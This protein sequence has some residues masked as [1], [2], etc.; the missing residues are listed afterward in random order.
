V[1]VWPAI[2]GRKTRLINRTFYFA[3]L[4]KYSDVL[5]SAATVSQP[6]HNTGVFQVMVWQQVTQLTSHLTKQWQAFTRTA[7]QQ[8]RD[9]LQTT[10][11]RKLRLNSTSR[12]ISPKQPRPSLTNKPTKTYV[13]RQQHS[14]HTQPIFNTLQYLQDHPPLL[15]NSSSEAT[16]R[17]SSTP[18]ATS[19]R[20]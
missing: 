15:T 14:H 12:H 16:C 6:S 19:S 18:C 2:S 11:N 7:N 5:K 3:Y 9:S 8:P 20:L 17:P 13:D 1:P 10:R 4:S